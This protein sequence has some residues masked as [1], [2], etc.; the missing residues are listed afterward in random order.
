MEE[1]VGKG[2]V[3]GIVFLRNNASPVSASGRAGKP[4]IM[5]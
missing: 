1:E 2:R 5:Y 4:I 3:Y